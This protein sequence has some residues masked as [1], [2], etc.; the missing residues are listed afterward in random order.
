M[1]CVGVFNKTL[2]GIAQQ[3][4]VARAGM[5]NRRDRDRSRQGRHVAAIEERWPLKLPTR[6]RRAREPR[7]LGER[8]PDSGQSYSL[9]GIHACRAIFAVLKDVTD[10][11]QSASH[12]AR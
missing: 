4:S 7:P 1:N 9:W 5:E 6:L 10:R 11:G 12:S 3:L 2:G 8:W